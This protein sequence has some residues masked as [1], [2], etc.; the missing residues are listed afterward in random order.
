MAEL[1]T[2]DPGTTL[3]GSILAGDLALTVTSATGFPGSGNF[4]IRI[5]NEIILVTAVAG[6]VFTILR[7]QEGTTAANHSSGATVN[8]YLTAGALDAIRSNMN[9]QG[10]YANR[11]TVSKAGDMYSC[12]DRNLKFVNNGSAWIP[13]YGS[14]K[15]DDLTGYTYTTYSAVS[16][17]LTSSQPITIKK[18]A[19]GSYF[20]SP[21]ITVPGT[22]ATIVWRGV[23]TP[24]VN[25]D[26]WYTP[27]LLINTAGNKAVS[28]GWNYGAAARAGVRYNISGTTLSV[29]ANYQ[30]S[31]TNTAAWMLGAL[32]KPMWY[33]MVLTATT[34]TSYYS[35]D[36]TTWV[37]NGTAQNYSD[38]LTTYPDKIAFGLEGDS[39]VVVMDTYNF[40]AD[41][42]VSITI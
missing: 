26:W 21:N 17:T 14:E 41:S 11:P 12:S 5:N 18:A 13:Y 30:T 34:Y 16:A 10:T 32:T 8:H 31:V 39:D 28:Y 36:Q 3:N 2:N 27:I 7:G 37:P 23:V 4:R 15:G 6:A 19:T 38:F 22:S 1:Y 40:R 33:A 35:Y 42:G 25:A 29:S 20:R 9:S 24:T